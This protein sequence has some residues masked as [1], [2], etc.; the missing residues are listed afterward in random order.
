MPGKQPYMVWLQFNDN[1]AFMEFYKKVASCFSKKPNRKIKIHATL[2]RYKG[3][4][5]AVPPQV[6]SDNATVQI[7]KVVLYESILK[8]SGAAYLLVQKYLL[9]R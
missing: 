2:A 3:E 4:I 6:F 7:E 8:P 1:A 9:N 5:N